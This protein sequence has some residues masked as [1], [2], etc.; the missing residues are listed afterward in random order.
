MAIERRLRHRLVA[1][2]QLPLRLRFEGRQSQGTLR[3]LRGRLGRVGLADI[4]RT[5][6]R[7]ALPSSPQTLQARPC[8]Y[9]YAR[10]PVPISLK[11]GG[12]LV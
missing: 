3:D 6:Y 10:H 7:V 9:G 2:A 11:T 8:M 5:A 12:Q 4:F 1:W